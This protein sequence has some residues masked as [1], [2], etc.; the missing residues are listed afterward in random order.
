VEEEECGCLHARRPNFRGHLKSANIIYKIIIMSCRITTM[1]LLGL[2]YWPIRSDD[3]E[4]T[5]K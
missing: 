2:K 4:M 5:W 1:S 3:V